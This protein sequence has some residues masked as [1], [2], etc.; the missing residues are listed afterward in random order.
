MV[1]VRVRPYNCARRSADTRDV[2]PNTLSSIFADFGQVGVLLVS[3]QQNKSF[4]RHKMIYF[5]L[6]QVGFNVRY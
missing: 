2:N 5:P 6:S 1:R 4:I 3:I